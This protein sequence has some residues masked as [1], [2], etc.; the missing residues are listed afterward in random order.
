MLDSCFSKTQ[1]LGF[2]SRVRQENFDF[3]DIQPFRFCHLFTSRLDLVSKVTIP[4]TP[5]VAIAQSHRDTI[6]QSPRDTVAQSPRDTIAQSPR[7]TIAQFPR[8]RVAQSPRDTI[9][10][11]LK[12]TI[13]QTPRDTKS[14]TPRSS[15]FFSGDLLS[16]P[17]TCRLI[18]LR[19]VH[20][21][22]VLVGAWTKCNGCLPLS[23][24]EA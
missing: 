24:A 11:T 12:V 18:L 3:V 6:A 2:V 22:V 23:C 20:Q 21:R 10:Q 4:E 17:P 19:V 14:Q 7:D 8:D 5:S 9:A 1:C 15:L 16:C 13:A